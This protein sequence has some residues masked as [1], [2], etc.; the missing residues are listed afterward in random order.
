MNEMTALEQMFDDYE[1]RLLAGEAYPRQREEILARFDI[2]SNAATRL[3][4]AVADARYLSG[5]QQRVQAR[6]NALRSVLM[7]RLGTEG[8]RIVALRVALVELEGLVEEVE[9]TDRRDP[10][11]LLPVE[12]VL[13][14]VRQ[15]LGRG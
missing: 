11:V 14:M 2:L 6:E 4:E 1:A 13:K 12:R 15:A 8:E 7:G 5:L 9:R 3:V 10:A